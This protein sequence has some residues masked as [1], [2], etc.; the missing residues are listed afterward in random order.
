MVKNYD[1]MVSR[2]HTILERNG[3][4][5]RR[6]DGRRD[7]QTNLLYQYRTSVCWRAIKSNGGVQCRWCVSQNTDRYCWW[8]RRSTRVISRAAV[9]AEIHTIS[10]AWHGNASVVSRWS[11]MILQKCSKMQHIL[12]Y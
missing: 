5:D 11:R 7:R 4:T 3:R 1:N 12:S 8:W 6:T 9:V 2:F 10:R